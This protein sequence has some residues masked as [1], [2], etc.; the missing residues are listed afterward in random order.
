MGTTTESNYRVIRTSKSIIPAKNASKMFDDS[1]IRAKMTPKF[2]LFFSNF[3]GH[4]R[5]IIA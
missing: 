1:L 5:T 2:N 4:S 3:G